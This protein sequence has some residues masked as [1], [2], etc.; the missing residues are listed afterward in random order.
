VAV[1]IVWLTIYDPREEP[2]QWLSIAAF[3]A[4][5]LVACPTWMPLSLFVAERSPQRKKTL[6]AL[7]AIGAGMG[8]ATEH[9][10]QLALAWRAGHPSAWD[11]FA[12]DATAARQCLGLSTKT[13]SSIRPP[14]LY[15]RGGG[16]GR[17]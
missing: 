4:S 7:L 16:S 2:L 15:P 10:H 3:L 1:G 11:V 9:R 17:H 5:A 6:A 12:L 13:T 14:R 8:L